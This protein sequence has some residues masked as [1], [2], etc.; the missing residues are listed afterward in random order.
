[1]EGVR[2]CVV[3]LEAAS[4]VFGFDTWEQLDRMVASFFFLLARQL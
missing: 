4:I 2:G 3:V 1:M